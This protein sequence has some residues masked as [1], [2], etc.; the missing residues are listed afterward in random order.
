VAPAAADPTMPTTPERYVHALR[1]P[2]LTPLY[3][4]LLRLAMREDTFKSMLVEQAAAVPGMRVLD[5]GAGTGTLTLM[6]QRAQPAAEV[7]GVDGDPDVVERAR[8]KAR[9]EDLAVR[10]DT[11]LA[12]GLPYPD[13]TF[14]RVV[15]SLFFHHLAPPMK[16]AVARE[17]VRVLAPGGE[18]HVADWG[19]PQNAVMRL[20]F[21]G[22]QLLDG[23]ESTAENVAGCLPDIFREAGMVDVRETTRQATIFGTLALYRARRPVNPIKET[24]R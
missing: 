2:A 9:A 14:D 4:P 24:D 18:L 19:A 20:L 13:G 15:S 22:V 23:F 3:D 7:I 16:R 17:V 21:L 1:F 8:A 11:A 10:F 12:D 6:V 5:L